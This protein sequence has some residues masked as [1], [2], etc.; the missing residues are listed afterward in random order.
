ME[1]ASPEVTATAVCRRC[2]LALPGKKFRQTVDLIG[3]Y[4]FAM[5]SQVRYAKLSAAVGR[6]GA[7]ATVRNIAPDPTAS[8]PPAPASTPEQAG[9]TPAQAGSS[10]TASG[11]IRAST[12]RK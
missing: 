9:N 12:A 7:A 1:T 8:M 3:A 5:R 4:P 6:C 2:R 10:R 11:G